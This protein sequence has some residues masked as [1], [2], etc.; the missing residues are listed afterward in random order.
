MKHRHQE[1]VKQ[2]DSLKEDEKTVH[3]LL[4]PGN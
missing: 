1:G 3:A 4:Q 2:V